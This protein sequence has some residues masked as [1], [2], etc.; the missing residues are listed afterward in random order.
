MKLRRMEWAA[1][2]VTILLFAAFVGYRLWLQRMPAA[3]LLV[4]AET[5][6][7]PVYDA[8]S[9]E[10]RATELVDGRIDLKTADAALLETLPGIGEVLAQRIIAY[11]EAYG[12]FRSV[13]EI[14]NVKG[15]GEGKFADIKDLICVSDNGA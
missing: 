12:G 2:A 13:E 5:V 1:V 8:E 11:R 10:E 14:M 3:V 9:R 7:V 15:I 4:P 6:L